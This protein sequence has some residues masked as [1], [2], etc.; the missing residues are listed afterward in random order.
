MSALLVALA[1]LAAAPGRPLGDF[2][3]PGAWQATGSEGVDARLVRDPDGSLCLEYDFHAVSGY[4]VM[5]QRLPV[6]W[7][8]A[9]ALH[10][11][12]KGRGARNDVQVKLVDASGDNVWWVNRPNHAL[13][14]AL[15]DQVLR[16]RQVSFAWGPA[17]DRTLRRTEA[18]ELVVA[19]GREGGKG[20][21]CTAGLRLEEREPDPA[22]WPEPVVRSVPGTLELDHRRRRELEGLALTWPGPG[23]SG[24]YEVLASD[25]GR[26]WRLLRKVTGGP[27]GFEALHLPDTE[28]RHLRI[29]MRE[30]RPAPRVELRDARQWP[31]RNAVLAE[32]ARHLAR[33]EVPRAFLGEQNYWA[34]VGVDGGGDRSGLL[35]EDGALELG[36]G[37]FSVEPAVLGDDGR[38]L[39]WAQAEIA[40]A[41]R[42]GY[43]PMPRVGWRQGEI[44]LE[45]EAAADG[46]PGAPELLARYA[47]TNGS[48]TARTFILLLAVRP[49]QVNPPQ[50]FLNTPGGASRVERLAWE[51]GQLT[52]NGKRTLRFAEPPGRV[53]ALP[54]EAGLGLEG[55]RRAA[56]L[57]TLADPQ[58]HAS[59]LL[60]WELR[61]GPGETRV[62]SWTSLLGE[63]TPAPVSPVD[64]RLARVAAG[65]HERLDRLGLELP[66]PARPV[67]D[68][69]R[70]ALAHMLLSRD[71]AA[72]MPGTRSYAR[73]WIRDGAMMVAGLVRMGE[74]DAARDFVDW[75]GGHVFPSGKVPCCVDARGADPV[76]E[77]D[78]HGQYL[79]AVAEV[80][81]H[82]G[83]RAFLERHWPRVQQVMAFLEGLRQSTRTE[84]FR[85]ANPGNLVGLLPPS[86][87]HEGYSDKPAYS[88]W[89]DFWALRGYKDAVAIAAA[90]GE[91]KQAA[92]WGASRDEAEREL[93]W[94]VE[95]TAARFGMDTVAGAADRGDRDATST[96]M[97][98]NPAQAKISPLLLRRTFE[99]YFEETRARAT[100][101][102]TWKDYTPYELRTVG[103]MVRLGEPGRAHELLGWFLRDRR[104]AAWNQWAEVVLPDPREPHYL[105]D[106]PHAWVSSD[107]IRSVLD[108][109]AWEREE[110]GALLVGAGLPE[111]W[112]AAGVAVRNLS[113]PHGPLGY[114]L[115]PAPRGWVL[116]LE[117]GL[118]P[119][120][121]GVRLAW[122]LPGPLPR[123]SH[124]GSELAWKGRELLL[125]AGPARVE[126]WRAE[127]RGEKGP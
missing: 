57:G 34:L 122:P 126:L 10:L 21:L 47:L 52:V 102:R 83:D 20:A 44:S 100:G 12:W 39:T 119:P 16:S 71:R 104:P 103:A 32:L 13:P 92:G 109:L 26:R 115:S 53:T 37:G 125:P 85:A 19:A 107:Y 91:A 88:Y 28:A 61:L 49:W 2:R 36:R 70:T 95:A 48:A 127:A 68:T 72:L 113:T 97:A 96:T 56:P 6:D 7:P 69:L 9:F 118:R 76:V 114:R 33:G 98:L 73:S 38:L 27:G 35:S 121:G 106:M 82:T 25:D 17:A 46:P 93:G 50:Q 8:R 84:L 90:L 67:A 45:I 14:P 116:D 51:G 110:D 99:R 63:G 94:S 62:L 11:R 74:R 42:D 112:M 55:L 105:G 78:S 86:I 80:W 30:G 1:A 77:N 101:A 81:R 31:D 75:F 65:W 43:L 111:E 120:P 124:A 79:Y 58:G 54:L 5:R 41:L 15:A 24:P 123:A 29:R 60:Q 23:P 64:E 18:L 89:D 22:R 117:G 3:D 87:S 4:A 66:A 40:H 108:L 59:A